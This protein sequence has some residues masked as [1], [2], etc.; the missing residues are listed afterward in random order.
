MFYGMTKSK[1]L[2]HATFVTLWSSLLPLSI[3]NKMPSVRLYQ[4]HGKMLLLFFFF[5]FHSLF[6][7]TFFIRVN[8][9]AFLFEYFSLYMSFEH[10]KLML[11]CMLFYYC[12]CFIFIRTYVECILFYMESQWLIMYLACV[13]VS[14]CNRAYWKKKWKKK[15]QKQKIIS[16]LYLWD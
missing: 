3:C 16:N 10:L 6:L 2:P 1:L 11:L 12:L 8:V 7:S 9:I 13:S 14:V 5:F 4:M 15:K